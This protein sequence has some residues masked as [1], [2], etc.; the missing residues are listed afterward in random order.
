M[1]WILSCCPSQSFSEK[2]FFRQTEAL[3]RI[4]AT[5]EERR[6]TGGST[7]NIVLC[8]PKNHH[9]WI[10]VNINEYEYQW[11]PDITSRFITL[12]SSSAP[13]SMQK[14]VLRDTTSGLLEKLIVY[15]INHKGGK[16]LLSLKP[17]KFYWR[18][19]QKN[20]TCVIALG[21]KDPA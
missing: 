6:L 14:E 19:S 1:R 11:T 20:L 18:V 7:F 9:Q 13:T 2:L 16:A 12:F 4:M 5:G 15:V 21:E 10:S 17:I 3:T 8:N